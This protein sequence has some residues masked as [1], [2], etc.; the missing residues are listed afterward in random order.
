MPEEKD[1]KEWSRDFVL[2]LS[3]FVHRDFPQ[4]CRFSGKILGAF[5]PALG[6]ADEEDPYP[7]HEDQSSHKRK[8]CPLVAISVDDCGAN[9]RPDPRY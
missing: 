8:G 4:I 7:R 3:H 2:S 6:F 1:L 5:F 9:D